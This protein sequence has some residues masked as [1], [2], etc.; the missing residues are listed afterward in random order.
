[1]SAREAA[2]WL[3]GRILSNAVALWATS[4]LVP[5]IS[6][7]GDLLTL[8]VAGALFGLFNLIV[9]PIAIVLSLPALVLT[10]GLFYFVLNG[11]LLWIAG[12]VIPG[13]S[14]SGIISGM[15]GSLVIAIVNWV[16]GIIFG[17]S[18]R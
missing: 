12:L 6:F 7:R 17:D 13:Y 5:G 10:L 16:L 4:V 14:V 1:M 8:V 9:K 11:I 3:V 18:K 2:M 15:L